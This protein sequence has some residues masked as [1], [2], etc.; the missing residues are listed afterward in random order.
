MRLTLLSHLNPHPTP[1]ACANR[2]SQKTRTWCHLEP[3]HPHDYNQHHQDQRWQHHQRSN[4]HHL[5]RL[6]A[7][8]RSCRCCHGR[9]H[10]CFQSA[11]YRRRL[12]RSQSSTAIPICSSL[13]AE[14]LEDCSWRIA[15][16]IV[17]NHVRHKNVD[18][19]HIL[20]IASQKPINWVWGHLLTNDSPWDPGYPWYNYWPSKRKCAFLLWPPSWQL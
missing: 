15:Q 4:W 3:Q 20:S 17:T 2:P 6:L 13:A 7:T 8:G 18:R 5:G 1:L 9:F 16:C 12:E 11:L 19:T 14:S 10:Q